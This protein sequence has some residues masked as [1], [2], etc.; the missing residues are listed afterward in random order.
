M[1]VSAEARG[2]ACVL[3]ASACCWCEHRGIID[4]ADGT[5]GQPPTSK[6]S[7]PNSDVRSITGRQE[8]WRR[9]RYW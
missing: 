4:H 2:L 3:R 6:P 9:R 7:S 8:D 1:L 5:D